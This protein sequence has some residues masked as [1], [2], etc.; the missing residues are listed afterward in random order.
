MGKIRILACLGAILLVLAPFLFGQAAEKPITD[1]EVV[2]MI[3]DWP[4]AGKWFEDRGKRIEAASDGGFSTALFLDKDFKAFIAKK[5][6]TLE[7]FSYVSGTAFSLLMIV[8]VERENPDL[9]AQ[10]D[11]AI[12]QIQAGDSPAD[13]KASNIRALNEAKA[14][15]L[16]ISTDKEINQAELAIVR[17][18][19]DELMMLAEKT[20]GE[21]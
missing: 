11:D 10:F 12:A 17:N 13:E 4:A 2:K 20:K 7:R 15:A 6:W 14:A 1:K 18:R 3:A 16:A 19:Y 8:A 5:G 21:E 9:A